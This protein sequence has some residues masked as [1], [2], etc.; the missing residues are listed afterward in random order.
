MQ[1]VEIQ[2][3]DK[4]KKALEAAPEAIRE[5]RAQVLD[6]L[7]EE[8]LGAVRQRIGGSLRGI[9]PHRHRRHPVERGAEGASLRL[10]QVAQDPFDEFRR[11]RHP[12]RFRALIASSR[13]QIFSSTSGF[14]TKSS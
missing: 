2:G 12:Q 8:L 10:T 6:E 11:Q 3:L 14:D 5:A 4:V 9:D 1:S 7:G 13:A